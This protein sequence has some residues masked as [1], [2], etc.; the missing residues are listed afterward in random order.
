MVTGSDVA[1]VALDTDELPAGNRRSCAKL[2]TKTAL[3]HDR[4]LKAGRDAQPP[5]ANVRSLA[6]YDQLIARAVRRASSRACS[7]QR[8][9][10]AAARALP[11]LVDRARAE[12]WTYGRISRS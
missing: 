2:R 1:A 10:P 4:A 3:E 7:D 9:A 8:K 5:V 6:R 12:E 11:R